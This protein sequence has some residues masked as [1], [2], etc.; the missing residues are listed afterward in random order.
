M[1]ELSDMTTYEFI[2]VLIKNADE[3]NKLDIYDE[4]RMRTNDFCKA[5]T[6]ALLELMMDSYPFANVS[7]HERDMIF[8]LMAV[9]EWNSLQQ[10]PSPEIY[11]IVIKEIEDRVIVRPKKEKLFW[12]AYDVLS[13]MMNDNGHDLSTKSGICDSDYIL[14][15]FNN[16]TKAADLFLNR[17]CNFQGK[18]IT[19]SVAAD[20]KALVTIGVLTI[21]PLTDFTKALNLLLA[22]KGKKQ[23]GYK[24]LSAAFNQK[25][26][27]LKCALTFYKRELIKESE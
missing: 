26:N 25:G 27:R 15:A 1:N 20:M 21:E 3:Y 9:E 8:G 18:R 11:T 16:N 23:I 6:E 7:P 22:R 14:G 12:Y 5:K 24:G 2:E 4:L 13:D 19:S 17:V 10:K